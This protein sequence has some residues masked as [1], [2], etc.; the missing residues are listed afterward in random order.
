MDQ[1]IKGKHNAPLPEEQDEYF[2]NIIDA[3]ERSDES[4]E[5]PKNQTVDEFISYIQTLQ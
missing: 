2:N 4:I 5:I 3:V 1:V